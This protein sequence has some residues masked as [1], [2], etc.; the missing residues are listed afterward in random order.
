MHFFNPNTT[1]NFIKYVQ[2]NVQSV[3]IILTSDLFIFL[4]LEIIQKKLTN[5]YLKRQETILFIKTCFTQMNFYS[6]YEE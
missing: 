6:E 4:L 3:L 1:N 2:L 5:R